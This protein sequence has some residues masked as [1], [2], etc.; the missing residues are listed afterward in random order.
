[1]SADPLMDIEEQRLAL[2]RGDAPL[3]DAEVLRRY[4]SSL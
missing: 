1:M 2:L 3:E 4:S